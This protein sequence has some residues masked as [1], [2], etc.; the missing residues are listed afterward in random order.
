MGFGHKKILDEFLIK[1]KRFEKIKIK[2]NYLLKVIHSIYNCIHKG[3]KINKI[4]D[5]KSLLE[6]DKQNKRLFIANL[7]VN[8]RQK[9]LR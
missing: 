1:N 9:I 7:T 6:N 5:V 3:K 8:N 2:E 4:K